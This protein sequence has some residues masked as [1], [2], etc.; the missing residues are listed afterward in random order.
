LTIVPTMP[1]KTYR[2][3]PCFVRSVSA[4]RGTKQSP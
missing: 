1:R 4:F 2:S 3:G